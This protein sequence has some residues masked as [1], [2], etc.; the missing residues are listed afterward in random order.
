MMSNSLKLET[1]QRVVNIRLNGNA[2]LSRNYQGW[3][4][5][6]IKCKSQ[7]VSQSLLT[8]SKK[9]NSHDIGHTLISESPRI[10]SSVHDIRS[11]DLV[12][13]LQVFRLL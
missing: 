10:S 7:C 5:R 3:D 9:V 4:L 2:D 11:R 1:P 12:T 13:P 6:G 8:I